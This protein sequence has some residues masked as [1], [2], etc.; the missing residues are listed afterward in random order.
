MPNP[1]TLEADTPRKGSAAEVERGL[2]LFADLDVVTPGVKDNGFASLAECELVVKEL[3]AAVECD[4]V[5]VVYSCL[6]YTS[7]S[8]RD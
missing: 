3:A 4:P 5:V 7:P 2:T 8:P 1:L 6:L